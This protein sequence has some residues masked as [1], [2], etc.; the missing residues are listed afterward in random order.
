MLPTDERFE[1][2]YGAVADPIFWLQED[3]KLMI[4]NGIFE[5]LLNFH[6]PMENPMVFEIEDTNTPV[7]PAGIVFGGLCQLRENFNIFRIRWIHGDA[8]GGSDVQLLVPKFERG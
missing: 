2:G 1:A 3:F 4:L 6:L 5:V 8:H 7:A